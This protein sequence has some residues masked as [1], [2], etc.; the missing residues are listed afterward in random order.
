M[1]PVIPW[2]V[3]DE[4]DPGELVE[5]LKQISKIADDVERD[6]KRRAHL[7]KMWKHF[8][9]NAGAACHIGT[10]GEAEALTTLEASNCEPAGKGARK[11]LRLQ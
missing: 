11:P 9:S 7:R 4:S 10:A 2:T 6:Q 1:A 3:A 5:E 8:K